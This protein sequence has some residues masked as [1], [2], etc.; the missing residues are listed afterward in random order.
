MSFPVADVTGMRFGR[1]LVLARSHLGYRSYWYWL[2]RCDCGTERAVKG[3]SLR[4]GESKSCGCIRLEQ[5]KRH[6]ERGKVI[7]GPRDCN[8]RIE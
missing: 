5:F 3:S 8:I 4:S 7:N 2:C 6:N 1:W